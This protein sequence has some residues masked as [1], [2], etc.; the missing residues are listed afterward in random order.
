[1]FIPDL[2]KKEEFCSGHTELKA[3]RKQKIPKMKIW[4]F[5]EVLTFK[6]SDFEEDDPFNYRP[7]ARKR[8]RTANET[9][10]SPRNAKKNRTIAR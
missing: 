3:P 7:L 9:S 8:I 5:F 4:K 1:M 6:M 10:P 2:Q